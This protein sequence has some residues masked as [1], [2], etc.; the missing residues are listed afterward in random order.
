VIGHAVG[1]GPSPAGPV[2][3]PVPR[4]RSVDGPARQQH[5]PEQNDPRSC[6]RKGDGGALGMSRTVIET[7]TI[8]SRRNQVGVTLQ[9][10]SPSVAV[11][12]R[13]G[14]ARGRRP[15][16]RRKPFDGRRPPQCDGLTEAVIGCSAAECF[17]ARHLAGRPPG[18][19]NGHERSAARWEL[20]GRGV[21]RRQ[22]RPRA[23][24]RDGVPGGRRRVAAQEAVGRTIHPLQ[25]TG[26]A[27]G[28]SGRYVSLAG[29]AA[30][31]GRSAAPI[32]KV[33][34]L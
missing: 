12:R 32:E 5:R 15:I 9:R 25:Q 33:P 30:E 26:P 16:R 3:I 13:P 31:R 4:L 8:L 7:G 18:I 20:A 6:H 34:A 2:G 21:R 28:S 27:D 10:L 22:S 11:R 14:N 29:P 1:V 19:N 17:R 23:D 24:G